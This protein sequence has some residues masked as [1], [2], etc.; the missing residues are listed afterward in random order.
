MC[1]CLHVV[2]IAQKKQKSTWVVPCHMQHDSAQ[3]RFAHQMLLGF[4]PECGAAR[5]AKSRLESNDFPAMNQCSFLTSI[6]S[7]LFEDMYMYLYQ[8]TRLIYVCRCYVC[9]YIFDIDPPKNCFGIPEKHPAKLK[10]QKRRS[11][12]RCLPA[13]SD[14]IGWGVSAWRVHHSTSCARNQGKPPPLFL[15]PPLK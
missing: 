2:D 8:Y 11:S 3:L 6:V 15:C 12:L 1:V 7:L 10:P 4:L 9:I 5:G 13:A 14:C